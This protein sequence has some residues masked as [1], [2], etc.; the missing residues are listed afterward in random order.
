MTQYLLQT[1][2]PFTVIH[3]VS[4]NGANDTMVANLTEPGETVIVVNGG[5]WGER[6]ANIAR[7]YRK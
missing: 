1:T 7:R 6:L 4:G 5:F 2:S 3:Q